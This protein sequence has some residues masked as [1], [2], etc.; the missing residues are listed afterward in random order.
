M[1]LVW[2]SNIGTIWK[3][4]NAMIFT[5]KGFNWEKVMEETEV[6]SWRILRTKPKGFNFALSQWLLNPLGCWV[7]VSGD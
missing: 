5:Q 1:V 3:S 4:I 7:V 6:L 2:L